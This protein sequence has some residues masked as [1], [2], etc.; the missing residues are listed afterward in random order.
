MRV[1]VIG[2]GGRE[3]T[4]AWALANSYEVSKV[5]AAPG[6]HGIG[7]MDKCECIGIN[8]MDI[9][10]IVDFAIQHTIDLVVVGP[11]APLSAGLVDELVGNGIPAFGPT[12]AAAQMESSKDFAKK[13]MVENNI[14]TA[15][16]Q[17]FTDI[18]AAKTYVKE[19]GA[20][21]VIKA[22]GLASGKG[23]VVARTENEAL[24]A[25][26]LIMGD[27]IFGESGSRVVIE[28]FLEG[29]EVTIMAF[30]DGK[31][32]KPMVMAQDHKPVYDND[33][34]PNTG[35]MG[36]YSPAPQFDDSLTD[37]VVK[38]VLQ[39][40]VDG[41]NKMGI[42]YKGVLYAGLMV[43][44]DGP[45]V[46][47]FNARFGDPEAQVVLPRLKTEIMSILIACYQGKLE[48]IDIEW[49][50]NACVCVVMASG[51]YPGDFEIDKVITGIRGTADEMSDRVAIFH[52]ATKLQAGKLYTNGGRIIGVVGKGK[53][54]SDAR[55]I[56]YEAIKKI[57]FEGAHYRT[58]IGLR[59]L[60][61]AKK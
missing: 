7:L 60:G 5:Y 8:E 55:E 2:S 42:T 33:Q 36:T 38:K 18:D 1:L 16:Y 48:H 39:P 51:G 24:G 31:T 44:K 47:E 9:E 27:A 4:I 30:V 25:L 40:A 28:E 54:I 22:D 19:Q 59:A 26:D 35:G 32:V 50:D 3:H 61:M 52:A 20:P 53:D 43:T 49:H 34:G 17:T 45:K 11:E 41:L 29:E 37:E 57:D 14:P 58:D 21:I 12:K 15:A 13:L 56:A 6:N 46:I 23:V 10:E